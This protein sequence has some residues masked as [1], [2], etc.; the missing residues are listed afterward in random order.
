M[1]LSLKQ[2]L[3]PFNVPDDITQMIVEYVEKSR[4]DYR[5]H[6]KYI[7]GR[8]IDGFHYKT[9]TFDGRLD[10]ETHENPSS[11]QK[12]PTPRDIC[13]KYYYYRLSYS[14]DRELILRW[15][16]QEID[17]DQLYQEC[18]K[19]DSEIGV[20][21]DVIGTL[22]RKE[23]TFCNIIEDYRI[24][25]FNDNP[26]NTST[27]TCHIYLL[28]LMDGNYALARFCYEFEGSYYVQI[29]DSLE[30][31]IKYFITDEDRQNGFCIKKPEVVF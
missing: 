26:Y 14:V 28:K 30:N 24:M 21:R 9:D 22:E 27:F 29:S 12:F 25:E 3:A 19:D 8:L 31:L 13:D 4:Y 15:E 17:D 10:V 20:N 16:K 6:G 18:F 2:L 1:A 11:D 5:N 7:M 23:I